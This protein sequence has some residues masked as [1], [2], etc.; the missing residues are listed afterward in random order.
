MNVPFQENSRKCFSVWNKPTAMISDNWVREL[1]KRDQ[2][3]FPSK[4][5][6]RTYIGIKSHSRGHA[7]RQIRQGTHQDRS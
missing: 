7:N 6:L 5:T 2:S 3:V 1:G 4:H